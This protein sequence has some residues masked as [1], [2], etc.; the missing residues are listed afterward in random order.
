MANLNI[1]DIQGNTTAESK[2]VNDIKNAIVNEFNGNIDSS[3]LADDAVTANKLADNAVTTNSIVDEAVTASKLAEDAVTADKVDWSAT[4]ANSGMW[5]EELGRTTLTSTNSIIDV[6]NLPARDYLMVLA[7][8]NPSTS[9]NVGYYFNN[10][11]GTNYAYRYSANHGATTI[12]TSITRLESD[13]GLPP[14][15][16]STVLDIVNK[17]GELKIVHFKVSQ[18]ETDNASTAPDVFEGVGKWN[19]T[20]QISRI[21]FSTTSNTFAAGSEV[22]VLGHN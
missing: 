6:Q 7:Y 11:T 5:W 15:S 19:N 2:D 10:D 18:L 8:L 20:S 22:I 3:N 9:M 16:T 14:S 21:S 1:P 12:G 4:G 17:S 13:T